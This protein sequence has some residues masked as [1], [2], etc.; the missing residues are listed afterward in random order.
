MAP[1]FL[2]VSLVFGV[3]G[4]MGMSSGLVFAAESEGEEVVEPG[5]VGRLEEMVEKMVKKHSLAGLLIVH[6]LSPLEEGF[7]IRLIMPEL[8]P[9]Y[10]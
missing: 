8:H 3:T 4:E 9:C 1:F 2:A 6:R 10:E 7:M 5:K